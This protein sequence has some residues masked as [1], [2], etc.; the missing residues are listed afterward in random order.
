MRKINKG[1]EPRSLA[2]HRSRPHSNYSNIPSDAKEELRESLM[3]EQGFVCCYCMK[4]IPE[5]ET[6]PGCKIEHFKC[7]NNYS[8]LGLDYKNLFTACT[9]NQ[10]KGRHLQ[11]CD[12]KKGDK[13]LQT[14][15]I[16]SASPLCSALITYQADGTITGESKEIVL[17][18]D[19]IL[20]LN[21]QSLKKA[22]SQVYKYVKNRIHSECKYL[23]N[24]RLKESFIK[25]EIEFWSSRSENK[26]KEFF[27][28]A[29]YLLDKKLN[30]LK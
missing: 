1:R 11:T 23:G 16:L 27:G 18:I 14:I 6:S 19:E 24:K 30:S 2:E 9:G 12:S 5:K 4:R 8:D 26:H 10:A 28:V 17:E 22:R 3:R 15:D 7:Q 13:D 20:N 29:L 21:M 25:K